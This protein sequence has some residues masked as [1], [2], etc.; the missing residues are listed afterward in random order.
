M[1]NQEVIGYRGYGRV[2][3]QAK[4]SND[5]VNKLWILINIDVSNLLGKEVNINLRK[6]FLGRQ[7]TNIGD[8]KSVSNK[9]EKNQKVINGMAEEIHNT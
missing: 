1:G 2:T 3:P 4:A 6:I 5:A 7:W 9:D 8:D